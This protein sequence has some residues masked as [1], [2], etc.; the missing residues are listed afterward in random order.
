MYGVYII[1]IY[2]SV[3]DI[4]ITARVIFNLAGAIYR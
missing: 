4:Y 3:C 2:I 1:D